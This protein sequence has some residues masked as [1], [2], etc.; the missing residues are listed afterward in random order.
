MPNIE[1]RDPSGSVKAGVTLSVT[2]ASSEDEAILAVEN[3][4]RVNKGEALEM[5]LPEKGEDGSYIVK[6][7]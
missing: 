4:L 6:L 7:Q 1:N 2:N 5:S 3:Y